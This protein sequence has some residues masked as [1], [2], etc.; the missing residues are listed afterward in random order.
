MTLRREG[1][2]TEQFIVDAYPGQT[3]ELDVTL[4]PIQ[5]SGRQKVADPSTYKLELNQTGSVSFKVTPGD[6]SIYIDN[7]FYG[8]ASQFIESSEEIVLQ[9]GSHQVSLIRPGYSGYS[10]TIEVS[11][12]K[13][14]EIHVTLQPEKKVIK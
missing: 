10:A 1:Y 11:G 3:T 9:E 8:V 14:K 7:E 5:A 2:K 4:S 13:T 12:E 6:A